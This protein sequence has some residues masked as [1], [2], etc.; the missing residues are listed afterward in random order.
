MAVAIVSGA[1]IASDRASASS[2]NTIEKLQLVYHATFGNGSLASGVDPLGIGPLTIGDARIADAFPTWTA[3]AGTITLRVTRPAGAVVAGPV[4]AGLF[5][6]PV[7]FD[8]GSVFWLRA[9]FVAPS[10]PHDTG[11]AFAATIGARTGDED[12]VFAETRV[13]ATFQVRGNGARLNIVGGSPP[14][15]LPDM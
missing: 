2:E 3:R 11:T 4:S 14:P 6:T 12:D 1:L 8:Q 9:S 15:N 13:A 7:D 5:A 10:G